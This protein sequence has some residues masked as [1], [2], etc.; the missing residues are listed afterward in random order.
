M[1]MRYDESDNALV[2]ASRAVTEKVSDLMGK[3]VMAFCL[4][5][6]RNSQVTLM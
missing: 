4:L 5:H 3:L 2:R 6:M 1:K